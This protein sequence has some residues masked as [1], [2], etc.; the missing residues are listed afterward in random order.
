MLFMTVDLEDFDAFVDARRCLARALLI[1]Q[2][3][4]HAILTPV[5]RVFRRFRAQAMRGV[6]IL[7]SSRKRA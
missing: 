1:R 3:E 6:A 2:E 4:G 5:R 7:A